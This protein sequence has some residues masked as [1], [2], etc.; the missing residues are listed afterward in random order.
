MSIKRLDKKTTLFIILGSIFLTNA[1]LAEVIGV[2]IFSLERLL[3]FE[4]AK[5]AL[6]NST[7][8]F[9]L[10]AGVVLWPVVF[11]V[12]DIINEYFGRDGVKKITFLTSGLI[13]YMFVFIYFATGLPPSD[14][15]LHSVSVDKAGNSFDI[16]FAYTRIFRQGLWIIIASLTAFLVGQLVDVLTFQYI[17]NR[18]SRKLIWLRA[19]GSTFVSQF[20]DSFLVLIIAFHIPKYFDPDAMSF[21]LDVVLAIGIVNYIYKFSIAVLLTPILYVAHYIIDRYLGD[22]LANKMMKDAESD[23]L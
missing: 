5:I 10:T 22:E 12:T 16:D 9:N 8:D 19:T 11:I 1:I 23:E 15:W 13:I 20:I 14:S 6:F 2:K 21:D 18:T 4:P 17:R 3:G 7:Y